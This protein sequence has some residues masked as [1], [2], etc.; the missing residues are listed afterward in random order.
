MQCV[1]TPS[2][3]LPTLIS[4]YCLIVH[5]DTT[6][7][8]GIFTIINITPDL[9]QLV[10]P[11]PLY[12]GVVIEGSKNAL[13]SVSG[14]R[15]VTTPLPG[16]L[17]PEYCIT[18]DLSDMFN[19]S[20][21]AVNCDTFP[22][23]YTSTALN[24]TEQLHY[25]I[26]LEAFSGDVTAATIVSV[27]VLDVNDHPPVPVAMD[28]SL[29]IQESAL[30]GSHLT[31][32]EASDLDSGSNGII[33]YSLASLS[34]H[35][36]V[37][38]F[39][40]SLY[41]YSTLDHETDRT[42]AITLNLQDYGHP[43]L[44][45]QR[46]L[47][48]FI[49]DANEC[50]PVIHVLETQPVVEGG[51]PGGLVA[52]VEVSDA[53]SPPSSLSLALSSST[54]DCF[55]LSSSELTPQGLQVFSLTLTT[56]LD[57]ESFPEGYLV[58]LA[59]SDNDTPTLTTAYELHVPVTDLNESPYFPLSDY[60][61]SV[62][63]GAPTGTEV[64]RMVALDPDIGTNAELTYEI[65]SLGAYGTWFEIDTESGVVYTTTANTD[66]GLVDSVELI[67]EATDTGGEHD[68]TTLIVAIE[69][70][71]NHRPSLANSDYSV[72]IPETLT[73]TDTIFVFSAT[74]N[75]SLCNGG[76]RYSLLHS[77]PPVFRVDSLTGALYPLYDS[78]LDYETFQIATVVVQV[79][80]QG[81]TWSYSTYSTLT[82]Q[83]YDVDDEQ[84][85]V[86][87]IDC[88]CWISENTSGEQC[89]P[90]TARDSDNSILTFHIQ[91][92]NEAE[93]FTIDQAMGVVNPLS[94]LDR[95]EQDEYVLM[96]TASD[97]LRQSDPQLLRVIVLDENDLI[98]IY[99]HE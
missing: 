47:T 36:T 50:S 28:T 18:G 88:P 25:N 4:F 54:C 73:S 66:H 6:Q 31:T 63:E 52:K 89:Q 22:L 33:R 81:E 91:P 27:C 56:A 44:N 64:I 59:A 42:T 14:L 98:L 21:E 38:P 30:P 24:V 9:T 97:Q 34:S 16:L 82:I 60:Q 71:N 35:F 80:D 75:D 67:V 15:V 51:I 48:I 62:P 74:D 29:S 65:S 13:V 10:F 26:T 3:Y 39:T 78:S 49:D 76:L 55:Q 94:P 45:A 41:L 96:I 46:N 93:R 53:D 1:S 43:I 20:Q 69:D 85:V 37:H 40:V 17:L 84:P 12:S 87:P 7:S 99:L 68:T 11:Q 2:G 61:A 32:V 8:Y 86:D 79:Q 58:L 70:V 23:I 57:Y 83:V 90:L 92:G 95:E 5:S 77:E 72:T 19:I